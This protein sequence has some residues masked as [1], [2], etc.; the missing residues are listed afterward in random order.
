MHGAAGGR[1]MHG[2]YLSDCAVA[3]YINWPF[4]LSRHRLT[5]PFLGLPNL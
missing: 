2:Q 1:E 4:H 5:G 3:E